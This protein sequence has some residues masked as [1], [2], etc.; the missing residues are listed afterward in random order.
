[1]RRGVPDMLEKKLDSVTSVRFSGTLLA[2][3]FGLA[4]IGAAV[5]N[6]VSGTAEPVEIFSGRTNEAKWSGVSRLIKE[7]LPN[8]LVVGI[9]L[10]PD[11]AEQEM[12][13]RAERFARQLE[14]RYGLSVYRVD[15]RYSSVEVERGREKI[16]DQSAAV[17]LQQWLDENSARRP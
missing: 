10:H 3:D 7:W 13:R 5:G 14:G 16:D 8:A 2:F 17:I 1:M 15:E 9:P 11:G 6:T 12:T 4:R